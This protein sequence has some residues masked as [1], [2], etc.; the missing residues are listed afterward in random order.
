MVGRPTIIRSITALAAAGALT[1]T[2]WHL[3]EYWREATVVRW[4]GDHAIILATTDPSADPTDLQ[5]LGDAIGDARIV[6]VG[7]ATHGTRE[8]SRYKHRLLRYLLCLLR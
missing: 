2:G 1:A 8:H 5:P 6:G 3:F 4:L 7:E